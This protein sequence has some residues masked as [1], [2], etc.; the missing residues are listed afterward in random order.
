MIKRKNRTGTDN[1]LN[2]IFAQDLFDIKGCK[3]NKIKVF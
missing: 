2:T 1:N 3:A